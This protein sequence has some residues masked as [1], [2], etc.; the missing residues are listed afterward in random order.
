[1]GHS[2]WLLM[3][4]IIITN[5][6][7]PI[8][9]VTGRMTFLNEAPAIRTRLM[10][11]YIVFMFLGGGFGSWAGTSA[12]DAW[13]WSGNAGLALAMSVASVA[14]SLFAYRWKADEV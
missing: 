7:G 2:L 5:I 10:T 13:G 12:Y 8:L 1:F 6:F 4:P 3:I 11:I 14:L 9:D